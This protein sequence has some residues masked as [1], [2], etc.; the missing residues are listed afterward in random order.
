MPPPLSVLAKRVDGKIVVAPAPAVLNLSLS[1]LP[2][3]DGHEITLY[4]TAKL[5]LVD[6]PADRQLFCEQFLAGNDVISIDAVR[7]YFVTPLTQAAT[8]FVAQHDA[9]HCQRQQST[10]DTLMRQRID[11]IAFGCGLELAAPLTVVIDSPS[12]SRDRL[13]K[14]A[15]RRQL[16][17]LDHAAELSAKLASVGPVT[18]LPLSEQAR[19]LP[20]MLAA[21]RPAALWLAA[22]P[23]VVVI[24]PEGTLTVQAAPVGVG[25]LRCV[26]DLGNGRRA[27]GGTTGVAVVDEN[28]KLIKLY[29]GGDGSGRGFSSVVDIGETLLA[30]HGGIGLA[31]WTIE[32]PQS[33]QLIAAPGTP[34][35]LTRSG[36][37]VLLAIDGAVYQLNG[38]D[39]RVIHEAAAT[40]V[41]IVALGPL[42][43]IVRQDGEL[44][45][46]DAESLRITADSHP[47]GTVQAAAGLRVEGLKALLLADDRGGITCVSP[48][49]LQLTRLVSK[50]PA[51]MI[52]Q[53]G[54]RIACVS[55]DR[56]SVLLLNPSSDSDPQMIN[57]LARTGHS[58]TD[59]YPA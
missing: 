32:S 55:A 13:T 33:P 50:S 29:P 5:A 23:N 35:L 38:G 8:A 37:N 41:A 20:A 46:L 43:A 18:Q 48:E 12:L 14:E 31:S 1:N 36:G 59:I 10:L 17:E 39:L 47:G 11:A 56:G 53:A 6:R 52:T 51:R 54:N 24:S 3:A 27:L 7:A 30:T 9:E 19:L 4:V 21:V 26:R 44:T 40:V 28:W 34:R 49:G 57:V 16:D 42:T 2:T 58:I 45:K 22:G 15:R 25:P